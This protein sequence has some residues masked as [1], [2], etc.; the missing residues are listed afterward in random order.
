MRKINIKVML[1]SLMLM[2]SLTACFEDDDEVNK[3]DGPALVE[4]NNPTLNTAY[5]RNVRVGAGVISEQVNLIAPQFGSDQTV[6]YSVD[7]ANSTAVA[8]THYSINGSFVIAANSSTGDAT[9][10][11]LGGAVPAGET[12]TVVLV[13]DGNNAIGVSENYKSLTVVIRP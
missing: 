6:N 1:C 4:F 3:Y 10:E 9:I 7:A 13:L 11:I 8:G 2:F 5:T 12:R